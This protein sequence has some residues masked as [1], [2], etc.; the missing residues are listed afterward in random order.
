MRLI[1]THDVI[2]AYAQILIERKEP[3]GYC[4]DMEDTNDDNYGE[5]LE[6]LWVR[7]LAEFLGYLFLTKGVSNV[8]RAVLLEAYREDFM[9]RMTQCPTVP[10]FEALKDRETARMFAIATMANGA[11]N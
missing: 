5:Q 8:R 10:K 7:C 9:V 2:L 4:A 6:G 11:V 3:Q 1:I